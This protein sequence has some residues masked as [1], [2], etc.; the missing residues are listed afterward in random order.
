MGEAGGTERGYRGGPECGGG[1]PR[2]IEQSG[3]GK[4]GVKVLP[5]SRGQG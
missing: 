1:F 4:D 2:D 3:H 5:R